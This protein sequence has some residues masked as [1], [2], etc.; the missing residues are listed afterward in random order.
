LEVEARRKNGGSSSQHVSGGLYGRKGMLVVLK[1]RKSIFRGLKQTVIVFYFF[2]VN[3]TWW[4]M[5]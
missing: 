4:G 5:G 1:N 2:G 3:K